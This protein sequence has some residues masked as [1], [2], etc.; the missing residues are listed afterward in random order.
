MGQYAVK[1]KHKAITDR[2][3]QEFLIEDIRQKTTRWV[4][5]R[6]SGEQRVLPIQ[7]NLFVGQV[8][9]AGCALTRRRVAAALV[10]M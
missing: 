5:K 7:L 2:L 3:K 1:I 9:L 8:W 10:Y 4:A 6:V